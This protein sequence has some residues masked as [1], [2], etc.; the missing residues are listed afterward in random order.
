MDIA[1][2]F[3]MLEPKDFMNQ[4]FMLIYSLNINIYAE[5]LSGIVDVKVC[6]YPNS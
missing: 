3:Q 4:R 1:L 2:N 5:H 6:I